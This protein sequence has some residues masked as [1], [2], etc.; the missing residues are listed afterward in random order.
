MQRESASIVSDSV[1]LFHGSHDRVRPSCIPLP[2][3]RSP[4][5]TSASSLACTQVISGVRGSEGGWVV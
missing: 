3:Q 2:P 5:R 1:G 4:E